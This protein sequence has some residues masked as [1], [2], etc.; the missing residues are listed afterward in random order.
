MVDG[1]N[2]VFSSDELPFE[3]VDN[4]QVNRLKNPRKPPIRGRGRE[5]PSQIQ[6]VKKS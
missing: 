4:S 1:S 3:A 2:D 5:F 6:K